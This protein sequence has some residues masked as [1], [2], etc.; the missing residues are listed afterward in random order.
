MFHHSISISNHL[1]E[2]NCNLC[3]S[4]LPLEKKK[5]TFFVAVLVKGSEAPQEMA[6]AAVGLGSS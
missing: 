2:K 3:A 1:R 5:S 4:Y 6:T